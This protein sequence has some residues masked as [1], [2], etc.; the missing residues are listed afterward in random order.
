MTAASPSARAD[1]RALVEPYL[2]R[3]LPRRPRSADY[4]RF[5]LWEPSDELDSDDAT[6]RQMDE[7]LA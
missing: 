2:A 4:L 1:Y 6:T 5:A 3:Y 7:A